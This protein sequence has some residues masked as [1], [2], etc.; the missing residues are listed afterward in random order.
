MIF[1]PKVLQLYDGAYRFDGTVKA[2]AYT[3]LCKDV[4]RDFWKGFCFTC[5]ALETVE[6]NELIFRIGDAEPLSLDGYAYSICVTETGICLQAR[7]SQA[8]IHGFMTLLDRIEPV[9]TPAGTSLAIPCCQIHDRPDIANRM[10]HFCV[11]PQT[12]LWEL[13]RF[14]R[15]SG[16]LKF[17]HIILEFWGTLQYDCMKE[18]S[19]PGAFSKSQIRPLIREANALGMEVI[20]MFNHW[21]HATASRA[22]H[23]KHVVLD[24]NPALQCY[25][26]PDGWCWDIGQEKVKALHRQIRKELIELCGAGSYFHIGCDEAYN[27]QLNQ[28]NMDLLCDFINDIQQELVDCGRKAILWG[29]MFLYHYSHYRAENRYY[30]NAPTPDAADYMLDRLRKDIVIA[31]WQYRAK[32]KPVETSAVFTEKGFQCILCPWDRGTAE[33]GANVNTVKEQNLLGIMHTTWH[34]LSTGTLY[35]TMSAAE[36]YDNVQ[37]NNITE[38]WRIIRGATSALLR[39]VYPVHG[40]YEKAGWAVNEI[41]PE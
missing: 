19:W 9:S 31:D 26:S 24:Q 2:W 30:C 32:I 4:F 15:M 27:F 22:V 37:V 23:G 41:I 35:I 38:F 7:D 13:E 21:G 12:Q 11:F 25:F 17:T 39:K 33:V 40:N 10:V 34:T 16:A 14:V 18:L 1:N 20:P 28:K 5:S 29:D 36:S 3:G 8:L 6:T